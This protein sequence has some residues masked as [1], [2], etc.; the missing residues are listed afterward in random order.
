MIEIREIK[1]LAKIA[2]PLAAAFLSQKGMQ[3]IETLMMS[4]IGPHALAA[5]AIGVS[6]FMSIIFFCMGALSSI[7]VLIA[8]AKGANDD[9]DISST[10]HNGIILSFILC[11]PCMLLIWFSPLLLSIIGEDPAVVHDITVFLHSLIWSFP[12]FLLF[13]IFREFIS[14]FSLT[15]VVMMVCIV[16]IPLVYVANY[17][18]IYGKLGF[19][20]QG[21]AG[22]GYAGVIVTW[23]MFFCFLIYSLKSKVLNKYMRFRFVR[24]N[25]QK[26]YDLLRL[27]IPSG[28]LYVLE[29]GM[30]LVASIMMGYFGVSALAAYQITIQCAAIAFAIPFAL[31]MTTAL[32]VGHAAGSK[33]LSQV[34][35]I[36]ILNLAIGIII[37]FL[38]AAFYI[39]DPD[40]LIKIYLSPENHSYPEISH[41][42][43]SFLIIAAFFQCL[44][45]VQAISN[46]ALRGLKDTLVPML[47]SI[48][49]Y[50]LIGML[51]AYYFS[52]H[53]GLHSSGIWVGLALGIC[54][55]GCVLVLRFARV[56]KRLFA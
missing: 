36:T 40:L 19:S 4:R 39:F 8:R 43:T 1:T 13:L 22:I 3:L 2:T 25:L 29:S 37:S 6:I 32:Q 14:A 7:G 31:G 34:K 44:D 15:R 52:F 54:C 50:W 53:T 24:I 20:K 11:I 18:L 38:I 27:G 10:L 26:I 28:T 56:N 5:G 16:S 51:S 21:I 42:A 47:L 49:S 33:N 45:A 55:S 48:G 12:G 23:F 35:R 9:L 17:I 30:F 41:F 46:G